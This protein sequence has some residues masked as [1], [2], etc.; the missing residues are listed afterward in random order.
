MSSDDSSL[1]VISEILLPIVCT[2]GTIFKQLD[3]SYKISD[4]LFFSEYQLS[5]NGFGWFIVKFS[6]I[7]KEKQKL[8]QK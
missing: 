2:Y 5:V 7:K 3:L 4:A 1:R 8:T 6:K